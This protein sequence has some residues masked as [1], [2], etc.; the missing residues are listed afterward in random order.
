MANLFDLG[1]AVRRLAMAPCANLTADDLHAWQ[2]ACS[3]H[4]RRNASTASLLHIA[5]RSLIGMS[6]GDSELAVRC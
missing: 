1:E 2:I 4:G 6:S 3:Q 5:Q